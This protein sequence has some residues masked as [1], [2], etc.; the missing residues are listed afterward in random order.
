M[1]VTDAKDQI[2]SPV[3]GAEQSSAGAAQAVDK[4]LGRAAENIDVAV[5]HGVVFLEG[6]G[7]T[8][9]AMQR[10]DTVARNLPGITDVVDDVY[11]SPPS[12]KSDV[13]IAHDVRAAIS[14]QEQVARP[15]QIRIVVRN[16]DVRLE[17]TVGSV[18]ERMYAVEAAK[19]VTWVTVVVD[20]LIVEHPNTQTDRPEAR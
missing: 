14:A 18:S 9:E 2:M 17:G 4:V 10:A 5:E 19:T 7:A 16:G 6:S 3:S 13:E 15:G 8:P 1:G 20:D 11:T 12:A